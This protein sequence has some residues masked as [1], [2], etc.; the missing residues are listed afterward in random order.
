MI[1]ANDEGMACPAQG[2]AF[3]RIVTRERDTA[4]Q[5]HSIH[6]INA[7]IGI[8]FFTL[9]GSLLKSHRKHLQVL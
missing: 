3:K 2:G 9:A 6:S 8:G 4:N 1:G 7:L 5:E